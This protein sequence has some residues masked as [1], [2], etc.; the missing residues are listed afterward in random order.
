MWRIHSQDLLLKRPRRTYSMI[1]RTGKTIVSCIIVYYSQW[2][3][4]AD[5]NIRF[6]YPTENDKYEATCGGWDSLLHG[7]LM[8][9]NHGLCRSGD[10][11][12]GKRLSLPFGV[13]QRSLL[14][15]ILQELSKGSITISDSSSGLLQLS[16]TKISSP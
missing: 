15:P 5:Y 8:T 6:L 9:V 12:P 14:G 7:W 11:R 13:A 1:K 16:Y 3:L 10:S 4:R 2:M